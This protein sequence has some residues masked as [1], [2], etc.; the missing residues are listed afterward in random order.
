MRV[1]IEQV[2]E[3]RFR[4]SARGVETVVDDTI[5]NGGPGDGFRPTELLLGAL[6]SCMAGTML[7]F[8]RNQEI[9]ISGITVV[10]EDHVVSSPTRIAV[11]D[12]R[13]TVEGEI[14]ER[15]TASLRR[16][17]AAC[18]IHNTLLS[19]PEI[20]LRFEVRR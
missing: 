11:I 15:Q 2:K 3:R 16:V 6:A 19:T 7:N 14:D 17:A 1:Q 12:V 8:A 20:D 18:K 4:L 13:M 10:V 5:E 9:P